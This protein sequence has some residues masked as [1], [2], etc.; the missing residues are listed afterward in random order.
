MPDFSFLSNQ[1]FWI[2]YAAVV[3]TAALGWQIYSFT[4]LRRRESQTRIEVGLITKTFEDRSTPIHL[5]T[6]ASKTFFAINVDEVG[7]E[8]YKKKALPL[9]YHKAAAFSTRILED[10]RRTL[11]FADGERYKVKSLLL[12][13]FIIGDLGEVPNEVKL[14]PFVQLSS[15]KRF[16]GKR[17]NYPVLE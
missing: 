6:V 15:G 8:I 4:A 11:N 12:T 7:F 1:I 9:I 3:S 17:L 10:E 13:N 5:I 16:F 2:A 14:R